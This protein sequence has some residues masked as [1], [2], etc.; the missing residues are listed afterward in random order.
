MRI[1]ATAKAA[2][3]DTGVIG[4][5]TLL[6]TVKLRRKV[7][8]DRHKTV[9]VNKL[10]EVSDRARGHSIDEES[11]Y[12][13]ADIELGRRFTSRTRRHAW[14]V[15]VELLR[16]V[17]GMLFSGNICQRSDHPVSIIA[18]RFVCD[19]NSATC[20]N[21]KICNEICILRSNEASS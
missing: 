7:F 11:A 3:D 10:G 2:T 20:I 9:R 6:L 8:A 5:V 4:G 19:V 18:I 12:V 1:G 13:A 21:T 14:R 17:Y 15:K 16:L